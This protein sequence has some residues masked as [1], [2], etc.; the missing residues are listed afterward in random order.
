MHKTARA[1]KA[2]SGAMLC[3]SL[4]CSAP[5]ISEASSV[6]ALTDAMFR[7]SPSH[8]G[9]YPSRN[10][11][12]LRKVAWRFRTGGRV[13]ASPSISNG[14]VY[15][16]S[17]DHFMYAL[18]VTDGSLLWKYATKG[19][20][21]S[22]A[23]VSRDRVFFSSLDGY[24]YALDAGSGKVVWRFATGGEHRY[25][26]AGLVMPA[27]ESAPDAFDIFLSSPAIVG[28][29]LYIGSGD[30]NVYALDE[31]TGTKK[32]QFTTGDVV[33]ASPAVVDGAV[34]IG[35]WDRF[36]YKLDAQ[37]GALLWKFATIGRK[38]PGLIGIPSSAAIEDGSV[39]FGARD[40]YFYSI[41]VAD[42][43]LRWKHDDRDSWVVASPAFVGPN[44]CF[45]TS[46]ILKF[47][48]LNRATEAVRSTASYKTYSFSSPAISGTLAFFGTFDG[49]LHAVDTNT[50]REVADFRTDGSR[51]NAS[52]YL[53]ADGVF[54]TTHM[55]MEPW[56]PPSLVSITCSRWVRSSRRRGSSTAKSYLEV[57]TVRS[58]LLHDSAKLRARFTL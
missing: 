40:G 11:P 43:R 56:K 38:G 50:G 58:T 6:K 3:I 16:G 27:K 57:P 14:I 18:R 48:C 42:G 54:V 41:G 4:A 30:H 49:L 51:K 20:V 45:T 39:Y 47:F 9:I 35:S 7:G 31:A 15:I 23:A 8:S 22:S 5:V 55:V 36:M 25:T 19:A 13:I 1:I 53:A 17:T 26:A 29:T 52:K 28:R 12:S 33:H 24:V 46:D 21:N 2:A 34:Y 10:L 32:W 37:T 44:V